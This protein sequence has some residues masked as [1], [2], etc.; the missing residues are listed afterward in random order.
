MTESYY[1]RYMASLR[2]GI[3]ATEFTNREKM[4]LGQTEGLQYW[5]SLTQKAAADKKSIYFIGN[6]ASAAMASHMSADAAKNGKLRAK[7]LN[8]I[9]LVTAI[10]N[11]VDYKSVFALQLERYADEGDLLFTIS[12]SGNSP[13]VISAIQTA[14]QKKMKVVTISGMKPDNLSRSLGDL[15]VYL[16]CS[17]YGIAE[18]GHQAVLHCWLDNYL[19]TIGVDM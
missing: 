15:N 1:T 9:S 11:D 7:C 13:N 3:E 6:G 18:S 17:K 4:N 8:D 10:S 14:Q 5:L 2:Q 16:P 12:S 19:N